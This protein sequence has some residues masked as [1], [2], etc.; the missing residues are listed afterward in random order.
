MRLAPPDRH[1]PAHTPTL[2]AAAGR[3]A[4]P[5]LL[6]FSHAIGSSAIWFSPRISK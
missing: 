1:S 6:L 3:T 2:I 4:H 5:Y